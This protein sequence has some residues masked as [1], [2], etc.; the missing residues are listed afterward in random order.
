MNSVIAANIKLVDFSSNLNDI[1]YL[2]NQVKST[3]G[4]LASDAASAMH[5]VARFIQKQFNSIGSYGVKTNS[6]L[7]MEIIDLENFVMGCDVE[8]RFAQY[9][10]VKN[11]LDFKPTA[12]A[13]TLNKV[14]AE[15]VGSSN[16]C[17]LA[18]IVDC[19]CVFINTLATYDAKG[20]IEV[21]GNTLTLR[22]GRRVGDEV[23]F[24][25]IV[26]ITKE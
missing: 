8:I 1:A 25:A 20:D 21:V 13:G 16:N 17:H 9:N 24:G 14:L 11:D 6:D 18:K 3:Y 2:R 22:I 5:D 7:S 23:P 26:K 15:F 12:D 19:L 10:G 4:V